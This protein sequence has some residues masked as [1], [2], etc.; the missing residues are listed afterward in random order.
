MSAGRGYAT[1]WRQAW[2]VVAAVGVGVAMIA[3]SPLV[4][5]LALALS[6]LCAGGAL[7][8]LESSR[9]HGDPAP[10]WGLTLAARALLVGC[11]VVGLWALASVSLSLGLLMGLLVVL[12]A[13]WT[14]HR[15][16]RRRR[17]SV[18]AAPGVAHTTG[19][20]VA[21]PPADAPP[22]SDAATDPCTPLDGLSDTA[23]CRLWRGTFWDLQQVKSPDEALRTVALR[24]ACLDELG[25]RDPAALRSWLASGA[26]ASGGPERFWHGTADP[27]S[28]EEP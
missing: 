8:M 28:G 9:K 23:L 15:V 1:R 5:A 13:P 24:Q 3:W 6:S 2:T 12:S 16:R 20:D 18:A 11:G 14:V 4:A 10:R 25:R 27:V 21:T 26:R 22:K 17:P 7:L 19:R